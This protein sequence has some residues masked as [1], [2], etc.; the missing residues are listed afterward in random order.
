MLARLV[1]LKIS[2]GIGTGQSEE[3]PSIDA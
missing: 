1:L 2:T 3:K